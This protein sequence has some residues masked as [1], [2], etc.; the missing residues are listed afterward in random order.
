MK[1][2]SLLVGVC[3][4]VAARAQQFQNLDF[5][6]GSVPLNYDINNSTAAE[7]QQ[8]LPGWTT[9]YR[10][11]GT[12]E[13]N[14]GPYPLLWRGTGDAICAGS[15]CTDVGTILA[16]HGKFGLRIDAGTGGGESGIRQVG[17]IPVGARTLT[18]KGGGFGMFVRIDGQTFEP[19]VVGGDPTQVT[20]A[21]DVTQFAGQVHT[22]SIFARF[23][24]VDYLQFS[25][26]VAVALKPTLGFVQQSNGRYQVIF[27]GRLQQATGSEGP[28][29]DFSGVNDIGPAVDGRTWIG[30]DDLGFH[31]VFFRVRN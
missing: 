7:R 1:P 28:Y 12:L 19:I 24:V 30:T 23:C 25:P 14:P 18:F 11:P 2:L 8:I 15:P 21:V 31:G 27:T 26:T 10:S 5:E 9:Y 29:H 22:L 6:L 13:D 17:E 20:F 16:L 3:L 4:A